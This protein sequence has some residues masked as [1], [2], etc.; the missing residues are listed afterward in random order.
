MQFPQPLDAYTHAHNSL[1]VFPSV[2]VYPQCVRGTWC[3]NG[4]V[5]Q[6]STRVIYLDP[7]LTSMQQMILLRI[8]LSCEHRVS[9]DATVSVDSNASHTRCASAVILHQPCELHII[10][11]TLEPTNFQRHQSHKPLDPS[12]HV[13]S[14]QHV[15]NSEVGGYR[16]PTCFLV[17]EEFVV[18]FAWNLVAAFED[19]RWHLLFT[20]L[21]SFLIPHVLS[22][23][24]RIPVR[25]WR[26]SVSYLRV[27]R[28]TQHHTWRSERIIGC[29][30]WSAVNICDSSEA[31]NAVEIELNMCS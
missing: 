3:R 26:I 21:C 5:T 28:L 11:K 27:R 24:L 22:V 19:H 16:K 25:F 7:T 30:L 6:P 23:S 29:V 2:C 15:I 13:D 1:D 8:W 14:E 12:P 20:R 31:S 10:S 17:I 9:T 4:R 18:Q